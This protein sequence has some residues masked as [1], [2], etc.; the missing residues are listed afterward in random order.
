MTKN[1]NLD[2]YNDSYKKFTP[3][4]LAH[5]SNKVKEYSQE[6][7]RSLISFVSTYLDRHGGLSSLFGKSVLE[8]GCGLGGLSQFLAQH[9]QMVHAIDISPLA[10]DAAR[11]LNLHNQINFKC[12]D[13]CSFENL[14]EQFDYII[15]SHLLHCICSEVNRKNYFN[16]IKRHLKSDGTFLC[17]TMAFNKELQEPLGYDFTQDKILMKEIA[18]EYTPIRALK[19][20]FD[21]ERE[22]IQHGFQIETF[23]YHQEL[24]MNI[25]PEIINYPEFRLPRVIRLSAQRV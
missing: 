9:S 21:L 3:D 16:F 23:F 10:I 4:Y 8:L 24:A 19:E 2:L 7:S 12:M 11:S 15:D 25:F 1:I 18:G 14:S 22:L 6:N 20:N 17:E 5:N 13:I